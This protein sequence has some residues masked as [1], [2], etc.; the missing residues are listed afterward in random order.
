MNI[1]GVKLQGP[2]GISTNE[3]K[4]CLSIGI[5]YVHGNHVVFLMK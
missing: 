2:Y 5:L 3:S 1:A 4:F